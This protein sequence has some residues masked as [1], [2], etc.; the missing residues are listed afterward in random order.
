M[1]AFFSRHVCKEIER[2]IAAR[3]R[4]EIDDI[5]E[6]RGAKDAF[7]LGFFCVYGGNFV[8][9]TADCVPFTHSCTST[10]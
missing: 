10:T 6:V 5:T 4:N 1:G 9:A 3:K 8:R 7:F 2:R